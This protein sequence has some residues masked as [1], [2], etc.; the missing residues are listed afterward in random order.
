[1][2]ITFLIFSMKV[3]SQVHQHRSTKDVSKKEIL[4]HFSVLSARDCSCG[5]VAVMGH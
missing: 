4:S 5:A 2:S 1:M 3:S